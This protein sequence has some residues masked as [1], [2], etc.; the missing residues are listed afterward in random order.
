MVCIDSQIKGETE[1]LTSNKYNIYSV[2]SYLIISDHLKT[3]LECYQ[4]NRPYVAVPS[5]TST[6][7]IESF[8]E[9]AST[10]QPNET[11]KS[12]VLFNLNIWQLFIDIWG[13][14]NHITD[15]KG[16][17]LVDKGAHILAACTKMLADMNISDTKTQFFSNT[18]AEQKKVLTQ[19][20]TICSADI[21]STDTADIEP[22]HS[23]LSLIIHPKLRLSIRN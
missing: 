9:L 4:I 8:L 23:E 3:A 18:S 14:L 21:K 11:N 13:H 10:R 6:S 15:S 22:L 7:F 19:L 20:L 17:L 12:L 16:Q 2:S 1:K 5:N